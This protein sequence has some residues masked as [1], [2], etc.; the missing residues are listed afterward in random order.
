MGGQLDS[1]NCVKILWKR[2]KIEWKFMDFVCKCPLVCVLV[3]NGN[4]NDNGNGNDGDDGNDTTTFLELFHRFLKIYF[5][6]SH[7]TLYG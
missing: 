4:D 3:R 2:E 7:N 1:K 6:I 5:N